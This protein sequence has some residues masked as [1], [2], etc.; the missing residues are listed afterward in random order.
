MGVAKLRR[1]PATNDLELNLPQV[2]FW[3][4]SALT[5]AGRSGDVLILR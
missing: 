1:K 2:R 5:L 3:G 4:G